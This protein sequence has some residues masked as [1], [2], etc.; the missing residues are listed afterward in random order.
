[1]HGIAYDA[2]NDEIIVPVALSGAILVFPGG[3]RGNEP[4]IRVIQ[5]A[6]AGIRP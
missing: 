5:G 2:V 1:M 3:A 4:P 6:G